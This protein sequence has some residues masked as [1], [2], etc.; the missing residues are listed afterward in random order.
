MTSGMTNAHVLKL[1]SREFG[2]GAYVEPTTWYI[3]VST[4]LIQP[5]GS[6]VTEPTD[7]TYSRVAI[8]NNASSWTTSSNG[9][10]RENVNLIEFDR[11]SVDWGTIVSVGLFESEVATTPA[12]F[13]DLEFTKIVQFNDSLIVEPGELQIDIDQLVV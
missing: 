10:G 4:T 8:S 11:A 5:S 2:D 6:G 9:R 3:G 1:L 12:Y 13:A 7:G